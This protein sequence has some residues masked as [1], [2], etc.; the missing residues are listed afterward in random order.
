M[1]RQSGYHPPDYLIIGHLT[2]DQ[3]GAGFRLGGTAL[4]STLTA[5]RMGAEVA[6]FT[7]GAADLPLEPLSG[8]QIFNQPGAGV[9][10]F[11]NQY[12]PSGRV[13]TLSERAP[14]LNLDL[15]PHEWQEAKIV[16]LAP[17]AREV[18]LSAGELFPNAA[19]AFSLQGWMRDWD[20]AGRVFPA[21]LPDISLARAHDLAAFLSIEDLGYDRSSLPE[22][23]SL[24]PLLLLTLGDQ[25]AE[26]HQGQSVEQV[27]PIP[28][29]E[30]DPTGAGDIFAG[31]F[32]VDWILQGSTVRQA[33]KVAS[34][35]AGASVSRGGADGI[36]T[37]REISALLKVHG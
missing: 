12:T 2:R 19:L 27:D 21:E 17:V 15:L 18:P 6:L 22:L 37:E 30:T 16:H 5:H 4:Y 7:S 1:N 31:A 23:T 24:F 13:Q 10:T 26:L 35:L 34:A 32:M 29:R 9:T 20:T 28:A 3:A 25:G 36:P 33:A 11:N 14:D 8:I